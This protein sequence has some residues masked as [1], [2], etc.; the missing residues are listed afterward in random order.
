MAA[1]TDKEPK[2]K[3][4]APNRTADNTMAPVTK[5]PTPVPL[6][7]RRLKLKA[8]T[9]EDGTKPPYGGV[10]MP[11]VGKKV[12][13]FREGRV[14]ELSEEEYEAAMK[15]KLPRF[16]EFEEVPVPP[17]SPAEEHAEETSAEEESQ[18]EG[19]KSEAEGQKEA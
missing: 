4:N 17:P 10:H 3:K 5:S 1:T 18:G 9:S 6:D 19:S 15:V 13:E 8:V 7:R 2:V 12:V 16:F 14:T 11:L